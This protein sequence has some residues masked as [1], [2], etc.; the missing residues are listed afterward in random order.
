MGVEGNGSIHITKAAVVSL[1][2][3]FRLK[4]AQGIRYL[5]I[6]VPSELQALDLHAGH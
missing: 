3:V 1:W 2:V 4:L 5:F 6:R